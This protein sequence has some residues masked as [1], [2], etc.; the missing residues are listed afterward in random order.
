MRL[1]LRR[2]PQAGRLPAGMTRRR[3]RR[4][5]AE[6]RIGANRWPGERPSRSIGPEIETA[7]T[8]RR[9][10]PKTGADTEATPASRW[11]TD[12]AQPRRR[13]SASERSVNSA[14]SQ[15]GGHRLGR[16]PGAQHLCAGARG[17][18]QP[19]AQRHR[20]AQA[21]GALGGRHA[22]PFEPVAAVELGTFAGGVAH[23][24]QH[25]GGPFQQRI[26]RGGGQFG[27]AGAGDEPAVGI[28]GEQP[29]H[30]Q[31]HR[32]P[33]RGRP[34]EAGPF[35]SAQRGRTGGGGGKDG[36]RLVEHADAA[37]LSHKAILH[38]HNLRYK[39]SG[40][41]VDEYGSPGEWR[42]AGRW[43]RSC[44]KATWCAARPVSRTCSTSTCTSS[45]R[46]PARR[47]S[48]A[49]G[50]PADRCAGPS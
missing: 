32:Q 36:H 41:T 24:G 42:W 26:S 44:G 5:A 17:E 25:L 16:L 2:C 39:V 38:S 33:V 47:P 43:R 9:P 50:W 28:A 34:R 8:T 22:H 6:V 3:C 15:Q 23:P 13:T 10:R 11:P 45:T 1:P 31:R 27:Q 12:W 35:A 21:G 20:G 19:G 48:T 18:R 37:M 7:A 29:V 46:S 30:L 40:C 14:C 49:C 4:W